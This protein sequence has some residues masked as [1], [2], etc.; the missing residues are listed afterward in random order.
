MKKFIFVMSMILESILTYGAVSISPIDYDINLLTEKNKV[1]TLTNVG[2][3]DATYTI[4]MDRTL[5]LSKYISYKK[6][7]FKLSPGEKKEIVLDIKEGNEK[8][9]NQEYR[10]K[11]YILE[12][13]QVK[14]INY[15][16]NTIL[17]LYGYAG[18][19]EEE[20]K[21]NSLERKGEVLVGDIENTSLKKI[22]ILLK[23]LDEN[24]NILTSKKIRVLKDKKFNLFELG[25]IEELDKAKKI[26][27]E[28]GEKKIEREI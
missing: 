5:P 4:E 22:D 15:E 10:A 1:Y 28:S 7:S 2:N 23:L 8:L 24:E 9:L 6:N 25:L 26:V 16:V 21:L 19:L 17:N 27:I 12:K 11:L 18:E 20:F 13:Q 14:N 3:S